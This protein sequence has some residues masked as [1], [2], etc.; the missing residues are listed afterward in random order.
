MNDRHGWQERA[1]EIRAVSMITIKVDKRKKM[2]PIEKCGGIVFSEVPR[3]VKLRV[4]VLKK[5][6]KLAPFSIVT[7]PRC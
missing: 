6:V 4:L 2:V 3:K 1:K 5:K 7:T